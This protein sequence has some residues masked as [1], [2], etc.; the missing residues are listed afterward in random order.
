MLTRTV[1]NSLRLVNIESRSSCSDRIYYFEGKMTQYFNKFRI[2]VRFLAI[3][4]GET[5]AVMHDPIQI[6][7]IRLLANNNISE[8]ADLTIQFNNKTVLV[9]KRIG[10]WNFGY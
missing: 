10:T 1:R 4:I 6:I 2:E 5:V 8:I 3:V 9:S 7:I